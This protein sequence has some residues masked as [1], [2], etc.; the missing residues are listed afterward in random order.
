[1]SLMSKLLTISIATSALLSAEGIDLKKFIQTNIIHNNPAVKI[2]SVT[3][4]QKVPVPNAPKWKAYMN[5]V[6]IT[7]KKKESNDPM[8]IFVDES[9]GIATTSLID[10]KTDRD[11]SRILKPTIPQSYYD[12]AHLISGDANAKH[13][14][15][16]FSDPQCPFCIKFVPEAIT[17]AKSNKD[18]ALYYYHMPLV[19]LHP[20]SGVLVKVMEVLQHEGK[21]DDMLK[22][23]TLKASYPQDKK[24]EFISIKETDPQKVL[25]AV[26]KQLSIDVKL[27]QINDTKIAESVKNDQT[28]G[29]NMMISGTPTVFVDGEFDNNRENFNKLVK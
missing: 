23:Y 29:I 15:V 7:Y 28:K 1:M 19:R 21:I 3:T 27:S 9:E 14:V 8:I 20:I 16:I 6:N 2:N 25:D 22:I 24:Q 5:L 11:Y 26:K 18:I 4:V 12:K 17:K 13:K 10:T